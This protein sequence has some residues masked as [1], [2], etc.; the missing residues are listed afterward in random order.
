MRRVTI[1]AAV[2]A[3][4]AS[5][6]SLA[7]CQHYEAEPVTPRALGTVTEPHLIEGAKP[8]P[9]VMLVVDRSGSMDDPIPGG[10]KKLLDVKA[11]FAS[12]DGLLARTGAGAE[13][14]L[15]LYSSGTDSKT[16]CNPGTIVQPVGASIAQVRQ[17]INSA[18][19]GG[20][21]PTAGSLKAVLDDPKMNTPQ[22][23]RDRFVMLLT[24]GAPNCNP[25]LDPNTGCTLAPN[26]SSGWK[27]CLD[28]EATVQQV[29]TLAS[30]GI[31]TFVIGFG[32]D[33]AKPDSD[34]Y[35]VLNRAAEV[36]GLAKTQ[37]PKF[38]QAN[39]SDDLQ[40]AVD[41]FGRIIQTCNYNLAEAPREDL[42][43]VVF[44]YTN[45]NNREEVLTPSSD[46]TYNSVSHQVSITGSRCTEIEKG[47]SGLKVEFRYVTSL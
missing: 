24:D 7:N 16:D 35:R 25:Q 46:W 44:V 32:S 47:S 3:L 31:R 11:K 9:Y 1:V 43:Q 41:M 36:G 33:T 12:D 26:C 37:E 8:A 5:V 45:E 2:V 18:S 15:I 6:F 42:L 17:S 22:A 28:E 34:A 4:V 21:T 40:K 29:A 14:G 27:C 38:Y 30:Q 23:G 10:T 20:G 19:A 39:S 13:F